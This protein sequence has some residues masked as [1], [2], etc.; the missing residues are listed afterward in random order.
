[1]EVRS[2]R[3]VEP[4][5]NRVVDAIME[6]QEQETRYKLG[7][8][9]AATGDRE[10]MVMQAQFY[11][12]VYDNYKRNATGQEKASLR[13]V[14]EEVR[15]LQAKLQNNRFAIIWHSPFLSALR[16]RLNGTLNIHRIHR[17]YLADA[18]RTMTEQHNVTALAKAAKAQS[19]KQSLEGPIQR[20]VA[21]NQPEF[22]IRH[23]EISQPD[24]DFVIHCKK[25]PGTD[26]YHLAGFQA[27]SRPTTES[28][29]AGNAESIRH[30]FRIGDQLNCN[31][32]EAA[33]LVNKRAICRENNNWWYLDM[34]KINDTFP[35]SNKFFDLLKAI[36]DL[37]V[38]LNEKNRTKLKEELPM[39]VVPDIPISYLDQNRKFKFQADPM[40]ESI[41]ILNNN[42]HPMNK[43]SFTAEA[44]QQQQERVEKMIHTNQEDLGYT[45]NFSPVGRKMK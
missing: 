30:Q 26:V 12:S 24:T 37:P 19:F 11:S 4:V 42:G 40:A 23:F 7:N 44:Q 36:E 35:F 29:A 2:S 33:A 5:R 25:I 1:M 9:L 6:F 38:K 18:R 41:H 45:V 17:N 15:R 22:F 28:L 27:I 8:P 34:T 32:M 20:M 16:F 31:A 10:A 13:Y 43:H 3:A 39:G 14:K 21:L